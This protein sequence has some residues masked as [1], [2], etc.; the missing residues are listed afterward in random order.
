MDYDPLA[1]LYDRQYADYLDDVAY[2]E[3]LARRLG[4]TELLELGAGSGRVSVALARRGLKVTGLDL[5]EAMLKRGWERAAR[6]GVAVEFLLGDMRAFDL[7]RIFPLVI[8][9]FNAFMHLY[10]LGDQDAALRMVSR[11]LEHGGVLAFDL[12]MP[13]FGALGVLRHEDEV[14]LDPDGSRTDVFLRQEVDAAAQVALT[15]YYLDLVAPNGTLTR[16]V[17]SLRQRYFTR[18]E[19]QRWLASA[20]FS[21]RIHGGFDGSRFEASSRMMVVEATTGKS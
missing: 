2:Y 14:F 10:T 1:E 6:E 4:V 9:P 16:Q 18:F 20:G 17:L 11:H 8:A 21:V 15:T 13:T 7:G 5:S 3:A 12:Y 19:V